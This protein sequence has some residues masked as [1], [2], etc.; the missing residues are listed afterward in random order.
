M[1]STLITLLV[2]PSV[3]E[4][5][6]IFREFIESKFRPKGVEKVHAELSE[7]QKDIVEECK[8]EFEKERKSVKI[9]KKKKSVL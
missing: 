1:V 8:I 2:V 5:I 6:D 9:I 7:I 3:F 4:Y